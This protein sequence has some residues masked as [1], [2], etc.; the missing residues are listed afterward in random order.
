[1]FGRQGSVLVVVYGPGGPLNLT[2]LMRYYSQ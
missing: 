1:L 2:R